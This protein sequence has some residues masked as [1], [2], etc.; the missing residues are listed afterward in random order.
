MGGASMLVRRAVNL[1]RAEGWSGVRRG[2]S[3]FASLIKRQSAPANDYA[4]WARRYDTITPDARRTLAHCAQGLSYRPL[5]S[6][7]MPVFDPE[8]RW[9]IEAIESV[10]A[11]A[12]PYWEL[13]IADDASRRTD[14]REILQRYQSSDSR[15]KVRFRERNGHISAA[16]NSALSLATGDWLVLFDHD[17]LLTSH[18]LF[19]VA[20]AVNRTPNA[21]IIYSDE[22]KV[23]DAGVRCA[24]HFKP[25]WNPELFLSYNYICHLAAYHR[26]LVEQIGGF[27]EGLEGAQDY[28]LALRCIERV[29]SEQIVHI[30]HVLYHWRLHAGSTATGKSS[31]PYA[32]PAGAR[33]LNEHLARTGGIGAAEERP[34]GAYRVRLD[35]AV[36][37][38]KVSIIVAATGNQALDAASLDRLMTCTDYPSYEVL[39]ATG[40][41]M[42]V[43]NEAFP[44]RRD[45][46][47]RVIRSRGGRAALLNEAVAQATGE[48]VALMDGLSEPQAADW[49]TELMTPI[50]LRSAVGVVGPRV[51]DG[52][53]RHRGSAL[54]L[55]LGSLAGVPQDGSSADDT[56]Y[57]HRAVLTQAVSALSSN[58]LL[59]RKAL[60]EAVGGFYR[61]GVPYT[62]AGI[63]LC[64][65][66]RE[67][68]YRAV[69]A[70]DSLLCCRDTG[71]MAHDPAAGEAFRNIWSAELGV[72][73]AYNPNLSL[74]QDEAFMLAW[75]PRTSAIPALKNRPVDGSKAPL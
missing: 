43:G 6:I 65:R 42:A 29:D 12:Y 38:P 3:A 14:V 31:K 13:C 49:L 73:T 53:G 57:F 46:R 45:V 8:P 33:A 54:I 68:G 1:Y 26:A 27:K 35:P 48:Y 55:G 7:I 2:L 63:D 52:Q 66:V 21:K 37:R 9:L 64:L 34:H 11:Q 71:A 22:D 18:A 72:D 10:R 36:P 28:D 60:Y 25:D 56:G 69:Y 23:T 19:W 32:L 17:D 30:P 39:L 16:S 75:P 44:Q 59:I 4:A 74:K 40:D 61:D 15:I 20:E 51:V 70:P 5:I 47:L 24:P 67:A 50:L 62:Y 41:D 58:C